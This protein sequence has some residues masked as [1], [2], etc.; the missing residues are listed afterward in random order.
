MPSTAPVPHRFNW[1]L[2]TLAAIL[3]IILFVPLVLWTPDFG[4]IVYSLLV[5]P[6]VCLVL[7]IAFFVSKQ[8]KLA[9]A[10]M[11]VIYCASSWILLHNALDIR[12]HLR[13]LFQ[14]NDYK[15]RLLSQPV[16]TNSE[17]RHIPW[18]RYGWA[19]IDTDVDLVYD[20][21]DVLLNQIKTHSEGKFLGIP[22][23]VY[24][25]HRLEPHW[26]TVRFYTST[27]WNE[28]STQ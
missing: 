14:S 19:T 5:A 24:Q 16:P 20:P 28:C 10:S 6:L 17:L 18:E 8:Q 1:R 3:A 15:A 23:A 9:I 21:N 7:L 26:F 25:I 13:W 22:C 27:S 4:P 11:L 12:S 2:A